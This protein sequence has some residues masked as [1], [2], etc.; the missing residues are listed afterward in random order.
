MK[1]LLVM[2][3]LA[4]FA[5]SPEHDLFR[6]QACITGMEYRLYTMVNEYR[7]SY[8]LPAV[9]MSA[10]LNYVAGAHAWD[11]NANRPDRGRCNMH[12]WSS[13]GPWSACCYTD[14]HKRA[15]C[16]WSKPGE[17]TSYDGYGYEIAYYSSWPADK[18]PDMASAALEGWKG[19]P[20]HNQMILNRYAWK[21]LNWKAM[22]VGICGNYVV[23]WFGED[24]DPDRKVTWCR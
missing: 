9:P 21:R 4:S 3:L 7:A 15:A 2:I 23:I 6:A 12:S 13:N 8:G 17:L 18:H 19:S 14:D 10:S 20:G 24:Q 11:L 22:G 5:G 16:M 1:S